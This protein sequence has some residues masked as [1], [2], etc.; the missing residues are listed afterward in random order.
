MEVSAGLM[1]AYR[2]SRKT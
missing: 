2:L 1:K